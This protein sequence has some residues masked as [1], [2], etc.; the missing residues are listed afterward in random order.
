VEEGSALEGSTLAE[1][2]LRRSC[3]VTVL[4]VRRG[5]AVEPN[6]DPTV[7]LRA[8]DSLVAFG[9]PESLGSLALKTR[10]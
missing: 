10:G 8:G 9:T 5:D 4:A 6:P 3:G 1:A 2:D 7:P